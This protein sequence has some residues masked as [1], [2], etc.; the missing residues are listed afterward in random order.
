MG[1]IVER[2]VIVNDAQSKRHSLE[3]LAL[4][5]PLGLQFTGVREILDPTAELKDFWLIDTIGEIER[6]DI[7]RRLLV[8]VPTLELP[9]IQ[10]QGHLIMTRRQNGRG[11]NANPILA[12]L[13]EAAH[14]DSIGKMSGTTEDT[15]L[16]LA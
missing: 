15:Y 6:F 4:V 5:R 16:V 12:V 3:Q 14:L 10:L 9:H 1:A 8:V 7:S 13:R 2:S 11:R